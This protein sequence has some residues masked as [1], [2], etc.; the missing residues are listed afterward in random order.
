MSQDVQI[1]ANAQA[2]KECRTAAE[3]ATGVRGRLKQNFP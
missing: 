1:E 2:G 3:K